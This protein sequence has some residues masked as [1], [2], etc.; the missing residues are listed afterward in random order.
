[1]SQDWIWTEAV[2]QHVQ[3][4]DRA[5]DD[6][7]PSTPGS[8]HCTAPG[9]GRAAELSAR[10]RA[11]GKPGHPVECPSCSPTTGGSPSAKLAPGQVSR[12]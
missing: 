3:S 4:P 12:G 11:V 8:V 9:P 5:A 10:E 6:P 1:M 2:G 7:F